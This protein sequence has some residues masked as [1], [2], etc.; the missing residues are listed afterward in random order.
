MKRTTD[1]SIAEIASLER[2]S[3][4]LEPGPEERKHLFESALS[5]ANDF[6]D[7]N[8][9]TKAYQKD[10]EHRCD[11][12]GYFQK[13]GNLDDLLV[14]LKKYVDTP[15]INPASP[16]H[17][18]YI[19]GG[20][21][22]TSAIADYL[23]AV[24]NRYA[25]LYY[26]SPGAVRMENQLIRWTAEL[27]NYPKNALGNITSGGSMANLI[28]VTAA[29]DF[30]EI[31]PE[32]SSRSVIY[33]T[34]QTHHCVD[35]ALRI[36]GLACCPKRK[37]QTDSAFRMDAQDLAR[38]MERDVASGLI[39]FFVAAS[40]G[41]TDTGAADPLN[42]IADVTEQFGAWLHLD[43]AYG[44]FFIMVD[45][46]QPLFAGIER[47]DSIVLDPHK[48][49]FLPYGIGI[50]LVKNGNALFES[51]HYTANYLQ[52]A[53]NARDQLSPCDLSPELTK[54]FR[55][56]RMWLPLAL[57][58]TKPI[59]A[60]LK[61]KWL[62]AR[63]FHKEVKKIGFETG[64][65]P[66][67]SVVIY[68]YVPKKGD[69]NAFNEMLVKAIQKDGRIFVSSTNIDGVFWLRAAM[70]CFRTHLKQIDLYLDIL[71]EMIAKMDR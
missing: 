25:G 40:S 44:G 45:E 21:L 53:Y 33:F 36:A 42:E 43:A 65:E 66:D 51:F 15:G 59:I 41:S 49:L 32:N 27:V 12:S 57:H 38:Q 28:A 3:R 52:D 11:F 37:I 63:Y 70:V 14:D 34:Q 26:A 17:L 5:Y 9:E 31:G 46:L 23:A 7:A 61:E 13:P 56:L 50:V 2:T 24:T 4:S 64:P 60:A 10:E 48:S 68:R 35:K 67:L 30:K 47:T 16:G 19:P 58:G 69:P 18:G 54:H 8:L 22:Y 1:V 39:P 20:G 6:L 29:R 62:L 55:G 71:A